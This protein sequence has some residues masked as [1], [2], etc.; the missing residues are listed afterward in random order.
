MGRRL[1]LLIA[2]YTYQDTG[3]KAL[4][5]PAHDAEALATVLA[6][7]DIAGFEVTLLVN[8][9][10]YRV[11]EAIADLYRGRRRDDLTLLYFTG[12]GLKDDGG[13]LYLATTNTRRDS[14]LFTSIPAEQVDQSMSGCMSRQKVLILDC[15]Y[16]GAFPAGYTARADTQVHTLERFQGRGRTVL[17]A[18]DA[19]Q[20]SF[21][22]NKPHG[23]A[24][25]SVFTRHLVAGLRDG[26]ADLDGDGDIALDEL[27]SYVH[28][29]VVDEMPQQR[30]KRLDNV[31]GRIIIARNVNWALPAYLRHALD[32][33]L[34]TDR[35]AALDGLAHL[36]RIG[37]GLVRQHVAREIQRL[38]EDDSRAVSAAAAR[39]RAT[40]AQAL[41]SD[42][43]P[44][45]SPTEAPPSLPMVRPVAEVRQAPPDA[46]PGSTPAR[47]PAG[48]ARRTATQPARAATRARDLVQ[49][50][51]ATGIPGLSAILAAGLIATGIG[52]PDMSSRLYPIVTA[53]VV[54]LAGI[55]TLLPRTRSVIGP[56]LVLGAAAAS[57]WGL[58]S[59]LVN[60]LRGHSDVLFGLLLAGYLVL[61]AA[62]CLVTLM[63]KRTRAIRV[64]LRRPK[65][66]LAWAAVVLAGAGTATGAWAQFL[67]HGA[68]TWGS[69]FDWQYLAMTVTAVS[70]PLWSAVVTPPQFSLSVI[71][72]WAGGTS[73][74]WA[75]SYSIA[76][77]IAYSN[78]S[79]GAALLVLAAAAAAT[80][81]WSVTT[82]L[83]RLRRTVLVV[84]VV[85]I[86]VLTATAALVIDPRVLPSH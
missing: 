43:V 27:Y 19:T 58:V 51:R 82:E 53:V 69:Y 85:V 4:T 64:G 28:D 16:S 36:H 38:I 45:P 56:G 14:L 47:E 25:Q 40:H 52:L 34:T 49:R 46:A 84:A 41:R 79:F 72:G 62:A 81:R 11:G 42:E 22:G 9:P 61:L 60:A 76:W 67:L 44:G 37:N 35:L 70:V 33:P 68:A 32:S 21:E 74:L 65:N 13:R 10:H 6:H 12:H 20:Y 30:P 17:T 83:V 39:L 23:A 57:T 77:N 1:T 50:I 73:A 29:R 48:P 26:S 54:L 66:P 8:E 18:S 5:S 2:A 80:S 31:E 75:F 78:V 24:Q 59:L 7:P 71:A 86:P 15:C 63:L 3:L 55:C